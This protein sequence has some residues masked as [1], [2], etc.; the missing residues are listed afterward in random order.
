[1]FV[2]TACDVGIKEFYDTPTQYKPYNA[3]D[4]L[5]SVKLYGVET[6]PTSIF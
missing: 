1:M 5:Q 2:T 4:K 6:A 3:E